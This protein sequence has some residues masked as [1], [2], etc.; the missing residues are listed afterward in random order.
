[1]HFSGLGLS[2]A[3]NGTP[4]LGGRA[5]T[6]TNIMVLYS[7]LMSQRGQPDPDLRTRSLL[8]IALASDTSDILRNDIG[9]PSSTPQLPF[10]RPHIATNRDHKALIR[11]TL[12]GLGLGL[13]MM[14][15]DVTEAD[16]S[17]SGFQ[18]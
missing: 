11:A 10:K 12:G 14:P 1:M 4:L 17:P 8:D 18:P 6:S 16:Q 9:S 13:Y 3:L 7:C 2:R 15:G 5:S